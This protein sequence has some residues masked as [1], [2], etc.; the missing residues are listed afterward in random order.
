MCLNSGEMCTNQMKTQIRQIQGLAHTPQVLGL[1]GATLK[2]TGPRSDLRTKPKNTVDTNIAHNVI[3]APLCSRAQTYNLTYV[4]SVYVHEIYN[5]HR[6]P[7]VSPH[8]SCRPCRLT[9]MVPQLPSSQLRQRPPM[10]VRPSL[11]PLRCSRCAARLKVKHIEADV[12]CNVWGWQR[13]GARGRRVHVCQTVFAELFASVILRVHG[14]C[15][16]G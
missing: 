4:R 5:P 2:K 15:M 3:G 9:Q 16:I 1:P 10:H 14:A 13:S 11:A 8:S 12:W 7:H 6:S